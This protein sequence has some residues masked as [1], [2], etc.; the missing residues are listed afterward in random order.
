MVTQE[1]P[2]YPIGDTMVDHVVEAIKEDH[3]APCLMKKS[4][5]TLE[6]VLKP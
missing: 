2:S 6:M 5:K 1:K 3:E 4:M